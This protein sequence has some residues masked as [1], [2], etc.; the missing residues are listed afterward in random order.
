MENRILDVQ[1][2]TVSFDGFKVLDNLN[3]SMNAG[4][5]RFL[6][7]P[8]GAGKTTLLDIVTG[9]TRA[10]SGKVVY[11]EKY[12]L[13][14]RQEHHRVRM[15]ISRKFQTPSI[16]S[17]LSVIANLEAAVGFRTPYHHLLRPISGL[18]RDQ[19]E[20][21]LEKIGLKDRAH[22]AAGK[23]SHGEKQWL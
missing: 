11:D 14:R 23:L 4:E 21:T 8:N 5:L 16:F 10:A 18:H 2:V 12:D 6:I 7:G 15:G 13:S 20:A 9:K 22:L 17:S 1:N 19:I 3:F